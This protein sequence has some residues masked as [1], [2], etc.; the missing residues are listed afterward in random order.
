MT[1]RTGRPWLNYLLGAL[2]VAAI[3]VAVL[4]VGPAS[5]SQNTQTR[6]ATAALG[7]V[8]STS[9]GSGNLQAA[10]QLNVNF[11]TSGTVT[12]IDVAAG[13]H[14]HAGELLASIDPKPAEVA[15][16]QAK[17]NLEAARATRSK[18]EEEGTTTTASTSTTA[19]A[20]A[21]AAHPPTAPS[22]TT[23]QT[24]TTE[25]TTA[26]HSAAT[27][28]STGRTPESSTQSPATHE[29]NLA[30]AR[31][32]VHSAELSVQSAEES[33]AGTHLYA[34]EA[35]TVASLS[36]A[37]GDAVSAGSAGSSTSSGT[38]SASGASGG[39]GT[40]S[41][42]AAGRGTGT[43][44]TGATGSS[45]TSSAS[46]STSSAFIVIADLSAMQMVVPFS[47]SDI[48]HI[49]VGQIAT[50]TVNALPNEKLAAHV[51]D[52]SVLSTSN[53]GVVSYDVTLQLE[54]V[55]AGLKPGMSAT[56]AVV[57]SQVDDAV[58]VPSSAV[59]GT[60]SNAS[61]TVLSKGKQVRQAV[62][63]GLVGDT[64]TQ[65]VSGL[66]AGTQVVLP[67]LATSL[68]SGTGATGTTGAGLG[69][70]RTLGG[71]GGFRAGGGGAAFGGG[72]GGFGGGGPGG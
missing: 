35:G 48:V 36:G 56:A 49:K 23:T 17:A 10:N 63:A 50:V 6:T 2:C 55:E 4:I 3:V 31:A 12:S 8:Q 43:G 30:S 39:T 62:A 9:S 37:V 47:E 45:S 16:E 33:L 21:A 68:T 51:T 18:T 46:S 41:G 72:G 7:V 29:A 1:K 64:T 24:T 69:G 26:T 28:T 25:S 11:K 60:G 70:A 32:A 59:T 34:P 15:L 57:T 40:T 14:V 22:P 19:S 53:S 27:P 61:V 58:N 54:Q 67:Q 38:S 66:K 52:V 5:G 13:D 71:G 42:S 20:S 65:I 44:A